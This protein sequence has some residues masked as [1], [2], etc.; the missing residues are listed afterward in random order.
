MQKDVRFVIVVCVE[1]IVEWLF[2]V[3]RFYLVAV[4]SLPF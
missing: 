1:H 3:Q 4:A 2:K